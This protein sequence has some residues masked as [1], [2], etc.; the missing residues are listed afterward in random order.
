[1]PTVTSISPTRP[2][3]QPNMVG[4]EATSRQRGCRSRYL[5]R[6]ASLCSSRDPPRV[7]THAAE[8]SLRRPRRVSPRGHRTEPENPCASIPRS[9]RRASAGTK[10][11]L[12]IYSRGKR[13]RELLIASCAV[14][15]LLESNHMKLINAVLSTLSLANSTYMA[16]TAWV[17]PSA[18]MKS[19]HVLERIGLAAIG[20]SCGLFVAEGL[21]RRR[22]ELSV[23]GW[24]IILMMLYGAFSFYVGIDLPGRPAQKSTPRL[25]EEFD[26]GTDAAEIFSAAGTFLAGIAAFL[27]VSIVALDDPVR[28]GLTVLVGCCWAIGASMQIAS[29][30]IA[31]NYRR[32]EI[33]NE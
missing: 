6:I 24:I 26:P 33:G 16:A 32:A 11:F 23:S 10:C 18:L 4:C 12:R 20:G 17:A 22:T 5:F 9:T 13:G 15:Y 1:L 27:S 31:R 2:I 19:A 8:R 14:G 21:M 28:D 3:D 30:A 29:G 7:R 25:P